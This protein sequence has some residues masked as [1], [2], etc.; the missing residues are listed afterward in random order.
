MSDLDDALTAEAPPPNRSTR[1]AFATDRVA[2]YPSAALRAVPSFTFAVP[3][4]WVL[5]ETPDA[6]AVVVVPEPTDGFWVNAI[7]TT[8]RVHHQLDLPRAAATTLARLKAQ[9]PDVEVKTE[10]VADF[11]G[12]ATYIRVVE[13]TA[14]RTGRQ[15]AQVHGLVLTEL[16]PGAKTIDLF[17][18]V[19]TCPAGT[20]ADH[21]A[22]FVELIA[23]FRLV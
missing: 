16:A 2:V 11:S 6:L 18:V 23:S 17:Q 9:C 22:R 20:F 5:D 14:P 21:G 8:D 4:G 7:I 3:E 1:R 15:L 13:M 10:R 12:Q 19:G